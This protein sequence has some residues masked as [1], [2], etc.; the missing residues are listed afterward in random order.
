MIFFDFIKKWIPDYFKNKIKIIFTK[1][2]NVNNN[3]ILLNDYGNISYSQE[4]EDRILYSLFESLN[5]KNG[6]YIDIGAH[7]PQRFSNTNIFYMRGWRGI[8]IDANNEIMSLFGIMRPRDINVCVGVGLKNEISK[9][10]IFDEPAL[11]TFDIKKAENVVKNSKYKIIDERFVEVKPLSQIL[12]TFLPKNQNIEFLSVD[13]EGRD[14]DVLKSNDWSKYKPFCILVEYHG[15]QKTGGFSFE[16]VLESEISQYLQ[17][18]GYK[19]FA[20]TL[21]TLFFILTSRVLGT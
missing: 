19:I 9:Y 6:F 5:I 18:K 10:Y 16:E 21:N 12:D 11:N 1:L 17:S 15:G 3:G 20:K 13:V 2:I 14:L 7:H 8:N 4:G